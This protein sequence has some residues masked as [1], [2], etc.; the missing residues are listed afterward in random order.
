MKKVNFLTFFWGDKYTE[1][2]VN[3]LYRA[4]KEYCDFWFEFHVLTDRPLT[5]IDNKIH[6]YELW[7]DYEME[8]RCW[9]R[10]RAF[11]KETMS[12]LPHYFAIDVD[13][14]I[15]PKFPELV[16]EVYNNNFTICRS[17]NPYHPKN[18]YSGTMWQVGK[19]S[20][21]NDEIWKKFLGLKKKARNTPLRR[22][23][24]NL[25]CQGYN[26]SD[27][28]VIGYCL[29]NQ[30]IYSIGAADG[31]YSYPNHIKAAGLREPPEN[32]RAILFH[33]ENNDFL[34]TEMAARYEFVNDYLKKFYTSGGKVATIES[35]ASKYFGD[36]LDSLFMDKL[37]GFTK[38]ILNT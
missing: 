16:K 21:V 12:F 11:E 23:A 30:M 1:A 26:G 13:V 15:M 19:L 4:L 27:S 14:L 20:W 28:A 33:G 31:I 36:D 38:E 3:I 5:E 37:K 9:R 10:L 17:E 2:H 29:Q 35:M 18:P 8:G 32:A 7:H 6:Q 34:R 25:R 22:L 24:N